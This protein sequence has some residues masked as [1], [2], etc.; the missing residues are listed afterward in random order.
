MVLGDGMRVEAKEWG[1]QIKVLGS[2]VS[3]AEAGQALRDTNAPVCAGSNRRIGYLATHIHLY[4]IA[5]CPQ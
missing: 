1:F 3:E 4:I 5:L 2:A